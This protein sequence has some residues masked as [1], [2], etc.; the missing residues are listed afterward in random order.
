MKNA[1]LL[2][3]IHALREL[4]SLLQYKPEVEASEI[5]ARIRSNSDPIA[6]LDLVKEADLLLASSPSCLEK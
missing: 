5:L 2:E 4:Y 3:E 6:V 1:Q